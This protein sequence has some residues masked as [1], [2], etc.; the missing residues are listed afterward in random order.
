MK[1]SDYRGIQ[2]ELTDERW[3]HIVTEHPEVGR[4]KNRLSE[5]LSKPDLVKCSKRDKDVL[6]YYRY[7]SDIFGGK[8]LLAVVK[9]HK[10][11][12]LLTYYVTDRIKEGG[13]I[14]QRS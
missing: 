3:Q 13:V 8:Y 1:I 6:L 12:F 10:R 11:P 14:W 4:F 7:Y 5:I 9:I 2:V